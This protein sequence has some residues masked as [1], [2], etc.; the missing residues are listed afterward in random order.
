MSENRMIYAYG[1]KR[2][3]AD[4]EHLGAGKRVF[5]DH[6]GKRRE[7]ADMIATLRGDEIVRVLYLRDLGGSPVADKLWRERIESTGA[8]VEECRP[9]KSP[10]VMG[11]PKKFD[12]TPE[13]AEQIKA[14]WLDENRS[15]A[16]RCQGVI[17]VWGRK[18]PRQI[19][20]QRFG[21]PGAPK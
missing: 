7:R 10:G 18:V 17:D 15:L 5:I 12:P 21:K 14:I 2:R 20:Y 16:D 8:I 9:E 3:S 4:L 19:L 11:R 1:F 6:D 13:Q